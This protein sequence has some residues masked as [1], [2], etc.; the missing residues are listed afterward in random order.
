MLGETCNTQ[1]HHS[2]TLVPR[3]NS[4]FLLSQVPGDSTPPAADAPYSNFQQSCPD[5]HLCSGTIS[6]LPTSP[7]F[8]HLTHFHPDT[9]L[10]SHMNPPIPVG[11]NCPI[12]LTLLSPQPKCLLASS[13]IL[14]FSLALI[15]LPSFSPFQG[16]PEAGSE[17]YQ[18]QGGERQGHGR[19]FDW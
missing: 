7:H 11:S 18:P 6:L 13:Q 16:P 17:D 15:I 9:L 5:Q 1:G 8:H 4:S 2:W 19:T 12:S 10:P 3:S 14:L